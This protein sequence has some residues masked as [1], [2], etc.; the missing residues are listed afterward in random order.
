MYKRIEPLV[1]TKICT[2]MLIITLFIIAKKWEQTKCLPA[3]E[4]MNK[5][6]YSYPVAVLCGHKKTVSRKHANWG[7]ENI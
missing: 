5:M 1:H 7:E 3:D 2:L 4:C 6:W